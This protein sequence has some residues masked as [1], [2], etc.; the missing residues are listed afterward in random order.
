MY[1]LP[2]ETHYIV[3]DGNTFKVTEEE[4]QKLAEY[5]LKSNQV[6]TNI[7]LKK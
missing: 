2:S 1:I 6:I 5:I 4:Y 3:I 7:Q